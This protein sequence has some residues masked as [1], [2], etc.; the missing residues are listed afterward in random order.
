M[1]VIAAVQ[2][3]VHNASV[4]DDCAEAR[5]LGIEERR[6]ADYFDHLRYVTDLQTEIQPGHLP[7]LEF[8]PRANRCGEA[9]LLHFEVVRARW[10]RRQGEDARF[11]GH[12]RAL[13]VGSWVRKRDGRSRHRRSRRIRNGAGDLAGWGLTPTHSAQQKRR[14]ARLIC[15]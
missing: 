2:R 11:V 3:Q 7:H 6:P 15:Q 13:H 14:Q 8:D 4:F 9:R 12:D 10:E 1:Q 5:G